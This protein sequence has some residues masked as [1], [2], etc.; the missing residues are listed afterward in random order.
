M[1]G[2]KV[3]CVLQS[4]SYIGK[5]GDLVGPYQLQKFELTKK[6]VLDPNC[7]GIKPEPCKR[8]WHAWSTLEEAIQCAKT[9]YF[10]TAGKAV[11]FKVQITGDVLCE[12]GKFCGR[13]MKIIRRIP[14]KATCVVGD[15][16]EQNIHHIGP[17]KYE[18]PSRP[19]KR[20]SVRSTK[21][22]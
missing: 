16:S 14:F 13:Y 1:I 8:G 7:D 21:G 2:Y 4:D 17:L 5:E 12:N 18:R 9:G 22:S 20:R 3:F 10:N 6:R 19:R 11:I 15:G